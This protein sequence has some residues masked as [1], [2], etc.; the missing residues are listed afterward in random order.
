[1]DSIW[2]YGGFMMS[3]IKRINWV[4]IGLILLNG[5]IWWS[6]FTNGF[7]TTVIWLVI[8]GCIMGI[9]LKLKEEMRV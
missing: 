4:W 8:I 2:Q 7:F 6:I 9:I 3:F 5:L 1:M